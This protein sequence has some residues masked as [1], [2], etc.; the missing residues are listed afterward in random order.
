MVITMKVSKIEV[1]YLKCNCYL[2]EK[3]N[4]YL[5]VDPG[6][7]Y[8]KIL[9]FIKDKNIL[10]ILITHSHNDHIGCLDKLTKDFNYPVYKY[11]TLTTNNINIGTFSLEV[12]STK[13]HSKDSISFYFKEEKIMFVGDF[14]FY[15]NIGRCDLEGGDYLEMMNSIKMIKKYDKDITLYPGHGKKTTI[16]HEIE[17]NYYF[18]V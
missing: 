14:I 2:I 13:G 7:E 17:N 9:K 12:L 15:E 1:G 11:S 5:L 16:A 18:N 6:A 4:E 10:G 3:D 8:N